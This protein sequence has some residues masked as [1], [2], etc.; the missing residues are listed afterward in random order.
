MK[1]AT[2]EVFRKWIIILSLY[3]LAVS[4]VHFVFKP[5]LITGESM[6]PTLNDGD[7]ILLNTFKNT[8]DRGCWFEIK[9]DQK[10]LTKPH[11]S[12]KQ[13]NRFEIKID[14]NGS[15]VCEMFHRFCNKV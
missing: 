13:R 7:R 15:F 8:Y 12:L 1:R 10:H 6:L 2:H 11:L 14:Q 9:F 3:F 4:S 5:T